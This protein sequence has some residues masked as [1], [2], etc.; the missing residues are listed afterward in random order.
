MTEYALLLAICVGLLL[1]LKPVLTQDF[2]S[3]YIMTETIVF[4]PYLR[5]PVD[6]FWKNLLEGIYKRYWDVLV[7]N[8]TDYPGE[9]E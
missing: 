5:D 9:E 4:R 1:S 7:A 6:D 3:K 2:G 8:A